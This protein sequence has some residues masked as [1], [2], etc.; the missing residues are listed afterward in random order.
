MIEGT[1]RRDRPLFVPK[2]DPLGCVLE[3]GEVTLRL[4]SSKG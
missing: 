3:V 4:T 2:L 1:G